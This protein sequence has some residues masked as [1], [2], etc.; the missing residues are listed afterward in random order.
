[1]LKK[2][3]FILLLPL[4][5]STV[6]AITINYNY[7]QIGRLTQATYEEIAS[8]NYAY[9]SPGNLLQSQ[10]TAA[11]TEKIDETGV[12]ISLRFEENRNFL[13]LKKPAFDDNPK[14]LLELVNEI[15]ALNELAVNLTQNENF[16]LVFQING[17]DCKLT[18]TRVEQ[19]TPQDA[20]LSFTEI[21]NVALITEGGI[22]VYTKSIYETNLDDLLLNFYGSKLPIKLGNHQLFKRPAICKKQT[23]EQEGLKESIHPVIRNAKL[24]TH[25][26]KQDGKTYAQDIFAD[27]VDMTALLNHIKQIS[28]KGSV[29]IN[30][31][32]EITATIE[33]QRYKGVLDY[34]ATKRET[35]GSEQIQFTKG[36]FDNEVI[37]DY[38]NGQYQSLFYERIE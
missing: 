12:D 7:D 14:T 30:L 26:F 8:I 27:T 6:N 11:A 23:E 31:N 38:P 10:I 37:I 15:P 1:M 5:A 35:I 22:K 36:H 19:I 9:D 17:E 25:I 33:G 32:N 24:L 21:G 2:S 16:N 3:A 18:P 20:K 4:F 13:N 34:R 28:E 29:S